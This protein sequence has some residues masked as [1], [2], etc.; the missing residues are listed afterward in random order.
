MIKPAITPEPSLA[1]SGSPERKPLISDRVRLFTPMPGSPPR[2]PRGLSRFIRRFR[3]PINDLDP[4][5]GRSSLSLL[6]PLVPNTT[7][8]FLQNVHRSINPQKID[9]RLF[10]ASQI[11]GLTLLTSSVLA[12]LISIFVFSFYPRPIPAGTLVSSVQTGQPP[13]VTAASAPSPEAITLS[14]NRA[15]AALDQ[16]FLDSPQGE[17]SSRP[18]RRPYALID[19]S[20]AQWHPLGASQVVLVP[21][22]NADGVPQTVAV[23]YDDGR[24]QVDERSAITPETTSWED[25]AASPSSEPQLFRLLLSRD[26]TGAW[27]A[28][29][30]AAALASV[31]VVTAAGSRL[32]DDLSEALAE[33]RGS[34]LAVD[35]FL[36]ADADRRLHVV[37][38]TKDKW[39]L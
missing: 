32:S 34:L 25:F 22:Q 10:L 30:P 20:Q 5:P 28:F 29:R 18:P 19:R 9:R 38:W 35:V 27:T 1:S 37:G 36:Q 7:I 39:V 23:I 3:L 4:A 26:Q 13:P 33:R 6:T 2:R 24:W 8:T 12:V 14:I 31:P 15:L 11:T 21:C 17:P 16:F